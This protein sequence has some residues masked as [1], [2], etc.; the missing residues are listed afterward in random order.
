MYPD[1]SNDVSKGERA[2][3]IDMPPMNAGRPALIGLSEAGR[4]WENEVYND[5][6]KVFNQDVIYKRGKK[7]PFDGVDLHEALATLTSQKF[8]IEPM[9]CVTHSFEKQYKLDQLTRH[10]KSERGDELRY[11]KEF[12]PDIIQL[13]RANRE[14]IRPL[15]VKSDGALYIPPD[16]SIG[17]RVIDIKLA[18]SPSIS[19]F[20]EIA[21][22]SL[23]LAEWLVD[24]NLDDRFHVCSSAAVWPGKHAGS[25]LGLA[26]FEAQKIKR[27]LSTD[28]AELL[29]EDDLSILPPYIY[30]S[31]IKDF[32]EIDLPK[33]LLE[34]NWKDL[35]WH[36]S[37]ACIGCEYLGFKWTKNTVVDKEHCWPKAMD[38]DSLCK[39]IGLTQGASSVLS[40]NNIKSVNDL[41]GLRQAD[42]I[43]DSHYTLQ[44][45]RSVISDRA[46]VLGQKLAK[47]ASRSSN[48]ILPRSA[49]ITI[50]LGLEFDISSGVTLA[51]SMNARFQDDNKKVVKK[52][53]ETLVVEDKNID[54]ERAV[55]ILW[56]Q[57][58]SDFLEDEKKKNDT[59]TFQIYIWNETT[60]KHLQR[61]ISRHLA[62]IL[63]LGNG[64]SPF[65]W[66]FPADTV[67]PEPKFSDISRPVSIVKSLIVNSLAADIPFYYN[68]FDLSNLYKPKFNS[69][70][71]PFKPSTFYYDPLSDHIP[72]ER[73]HDLWTKSERQG[74]HY[75]DVESQIKR[76]SEQKLV[77]LDYVVMKANNDFALSGRPKPPPLKV[78][79]Q[80]RIVKNVSLDCELWYSF[81]KLNNALQ[82]YETQRIYSLDAYEQEARF[83]SVR[84][85]RSIKQ[86]DAKTLFANYGLSG[87]RMFAFMTSPRS[88]HAKVKI[89]NIGYTLI[90]EQMNSVADYKVDFF[91]RQSGL[92]QKDISK[93]YTKYSY[94]MRS[95]LREL[96]SIQVKVFDRHKGIIIVEFGD[97]HSRLQ[98]ELV[99]LGIIDFSNITKIKP[100][101][102]QPLHI[103]LSLKKIKGS[104]RSIANP[105]IAGKRPL[106]MIPHRLKKRKRVQSPTSAVP[107][108][109]FI[110]N[111][112]SLNSIEKPA[113]STDQ[114]LNSSPHTKNLNSSQRA[115]IRSTILKPLS[116]IWGPPGTGKTSTLAA[117]ICTLINLS[118]KPI[119]ILVTA[120]T[121]V[122]IDT[123]RDKYISLMNN[124]TFGLKDSHTYR[125]FSGYGKKPNNLGSGIKVV[126]PTDIDS[127]DYQELAK[128]IQERLNHIVVFSTPQQV[129]KLRTQMTG[130]DECTFE[131]F[132]H[133][134]VDEASQLDMASMMMVYPSFASECSLTV[135]GDDKQMPPIFQTE[136]PKDAENCLGSIFSFYKNHW[137]IDSDMLEVNYR[138]N[139]EIVE[140][141]KCAGYTDKFHAH[142]EDA[143]INITTKPNQ[144]N[145]DW[146]DYVLE[147]SRSLVCIVHNDTTSPQRSELES[148]IATKL[149]EALEGRLCS[150]TS[151]IPYTIDELFERGIGIVTPHTA[152]KAAIYNSLSNSFSNR[153]ISTDKLYDAID[154]VE[155]FQG[156]EKDLIIVSY[157]LS[158]RDSIL[159]EEEF[160]FGLERFNVAVSRAKYKVV[161]LVSDDLVRHIP[162]DVEV[163][164]AS[165]LMKHFA[166]TYLKNNKV[167]PIIHGKKEYNL[168]IKHSARD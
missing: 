17:L 37:P 111:A 99:K 144:V 25:S 139:K 86:S 31:R 143:T 64:L 62:E 21:F 75:K 34:P 40:Q 24:N 60:F 91:L 141:T 92:S 41:V 163:V 93:F 150:E 81:A 55:L 49:N 61:V 59:L 66:M 3:Q 65:C 140:F 67:M 126:V 104:I 132:D 109:K 53:R 58:I 154:T 89:D 105:P 125:L 137:K 76:V 164:E 36:I 135:V 117:A 72:S 115:A 48:S 149:V 9:F 136:L 7:D 107:C 79:D 73:A 39:V 5:L 96:F 98:S 151:D 160:I 4:D 110:W 27:L 10:L 147:P 85:I 152:Q 13:T 159:Q 71:I 54:T 114:L 95:T 84:L 145:E 130:S 157:A 20:A 119:R 168:N 100:A 63:Q 128:N 162:Q 158:D 80:S 28:E 156:Q 14:S 82:Q 57:K 33:V 18:A 121:W 12:R 122:A 2:A 6:I 23:I 94:S 83:Y 42:K 16:S 106:I 129:S 77:A 165:M 101:I 134:I 69:E 87:T 45:S 116:L 35:R 146:V 32:L 161:V 124:E 148:A 8:I 68:L 112:D 70:P 56:L 52:Q 51:F 15:A 127:E 74:L 22:Y 88:I 50:Y 90:P 133:I 78:L 1:E 43:F 138:S 167:F 166:G 142:N 153:G 44:A 46:S 131:M 29:L 97:Y 47:R 30:T 155:R 11:A 102:I 108:D 19:Y 103:D 123:L 118:D 38:S 120:Y 113:N 26:F